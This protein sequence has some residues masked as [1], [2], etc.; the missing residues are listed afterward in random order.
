MHP[1]KLAFYLSTPRDHP[2]QFLLPAN[3]IPLALAGAKIFRNRK[4]VMDTLQVG[5][6]IPVSGECKS[7]YHFVFAEWRVK[8]LIIDCQDVLV[9]SPRNSREECGTLTLASM[10]FDPAYGFVRMMAGKQGDHR[11]EAETGTEI[12]LMVEDEACLED[13]RHELELLSRQR[14][15]LSKARLSYQTDRHYR[16][17]LFQ[18]KTLCLL[19]G[20]VKPRPIWSAAKR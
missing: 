10:L 11:E 3:K 17:E 18:Q 12:V 16:L 6:L 9:A 15:S 20:K 13:F 5:P 7:G 4:H 19:P 1:R 14:G 8:K 2:G